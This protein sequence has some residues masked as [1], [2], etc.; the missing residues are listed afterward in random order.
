V[1]APRE[2][3]VDFPVPL[4]A[5]RPISAQRSTTVLAEIGS[6]REMGC[7]D[8]YRR[9]L[10]PGGAP[11]LDTIAGTWVPMPLLTAHYDA[12]SQL[13]LSPADQLD[14]G[15]RSARRVLGTLLG[16]AVK[17][18][19]TAGATPWTLFEN[20]G[21]VWSRGYDGGA[22]RVQRFGPKDALVEIA[23]NPLFAYPFF[24]NG[25][26]GYGVEVIGQFCTRITVREEAPGRGIDGAFRAQWA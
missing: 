9:F 11:L 13:G 19:R 15:I 12:C 24:R 6:L 8:A 16:T 20:I 3:F 18:A 21:R 5:V 10:G 14:F 4:A 23:G 1:D 17:L 25:F 2:L 26:R 22:L 7:F